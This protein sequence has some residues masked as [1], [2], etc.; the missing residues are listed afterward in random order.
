MTKKSKAI[1]ISVSFVLVA[2][3]V[4]IVIIANRKFK[5][6]E[7]TEEGKSHINIYTLDDANREVDVSYATGAQTVMV[8][9]SRQRNVFAYNYH[10]GVDGN[11][12]M[13]PIKKLWYADGTVTKYNQK[14]DYIIAD[15]VQL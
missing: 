14:T 8:D 15:Y 4:A 13:I 5:K 1:I 11:W 7:L 9:P 12:T 10:N 3:V 6:Y 2:I